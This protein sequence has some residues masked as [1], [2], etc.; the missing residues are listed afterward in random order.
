PRKK[1]TSRA[2]N[3]CQKS[4]V[5]CDSNRPCNRCVQ[6]KLADSCKDGKRK[7]AKYM[8]S[9]SPEP[10]SVEQSGQQPSIFN[11][12]N[13]ENFGFYSETANSEYLM[14]SNMLNQ[15][16]N[17]NQISSKDQSSSPSPSIPSTGGVNQLHKVATSKKIGNAKRRLVQVHQ[18]YNSINK[19]HD[20]TT[21]YHFYYSIF[22][23]ENILRICR[24]ITQFRPSFISQ[25]M[26]LTDEDLTFVEK[27]FQRTLL[28]FDKLIQLS[29]TP[30][31]VWRRNGEIVLIGKEFTML[32]QWTKEQLL[33]TSTYIYQIM[34]DSSAVEYWER[35]A[36]HSFDNS[37][38][39][40]MTTC[41]LLTPTNQTV[42]CAYC[43][44]IKRDIFDVPLMIVGN[45]S[46]L[47]FLV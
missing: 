33:S 35:Y 34:D 12:S 16:T 1:K 14:L 4:H 18:I 31:V 45:V 32:T 40:V 11:F 6:R 9:E 37:E 41:T 20:Y 38:M 22:K 7:R 15:P 5:T 46:L 42:N 10:S 36:T 44:T 25:I 21:G 24:A 27:C 28:E 30:T 3:N 43:F 29:G 47:L 26:N 17:F 2:C 13:S 8:G 23:K 39:S 19:G